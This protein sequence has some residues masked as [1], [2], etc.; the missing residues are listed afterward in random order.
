MKRYISRH[1]I[2]A[3]FWMKPYSYAGEQFIRAAMK[4]HPIDRKMLVNCLRTSVRNGR[5]F[6][7]YQEH[8]FEVVEASLNKDTRKHDLD[9]ID[10]EYYLD[11]MG[12]E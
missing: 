8:G 12:G 2:E 9:E 10:R 5:R 3:K 6:E 4:L 1:V 11:T 7:G